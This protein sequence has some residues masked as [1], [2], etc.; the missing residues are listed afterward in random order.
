MEVL[1]TQSVTRGPHLG[2][3]IWAVQGFSELVCISDTT[4]FRMIWA[5]RERD[6]TEEWEDYRIKILYTV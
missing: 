2:A 4:A 5:K 3:G 6:P 1:K